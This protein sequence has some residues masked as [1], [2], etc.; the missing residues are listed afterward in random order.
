MGSFYATYTEFGG[1]GSSTSEDPNGFIQVG[2]GFL[3]KALNTELVF[4]S[5]M[6]VPDEFENQFFRYS[7]QNQ[8]DKHRL[9]LNL[10]NENGLYSKLLLG[11]AARSFKWARPFRWKVYK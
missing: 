7:T 3:V 5:E 2:Q 6:K 11:Y 4:N 9:W 10:T 8:M 1:V